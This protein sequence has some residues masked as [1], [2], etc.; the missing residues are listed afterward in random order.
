MSILQK[1]T[2][3]GSACLLQVLCRELWA[4]AFREAASAESFSA[5]NQQLQDSN[6]AQTDF[7]QLSLEQ[8][9]YKEKI[10]NNELATNLENKKSLE[11]DLSFQSFFFD[12]LA[13]QTEL[14]SFRRVSR[15]ELLQEAACTQQLYPD[16]SRSLQRTAFSSLLSS[17][18]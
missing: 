13:F 1:E 7:Q 14:L 2:F 11:E 10:L 3:T 4:E 16:S 15:E 18:Q 17:S 5:F 8:H 12:N 6:L 9:I